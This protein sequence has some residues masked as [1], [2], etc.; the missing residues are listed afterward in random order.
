MS[1]IGAVGVGVT[2]GKAATGFIFNYTKSK[3]EDKLTVLQDLLADLEG[4]KAELEALTGES[5]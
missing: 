3:Y 1:I 5:G 2:I 4:H